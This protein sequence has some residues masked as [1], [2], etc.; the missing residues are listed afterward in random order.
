MAAIPESHRDLLEQ[1]VVVSL[2]TVLPNDQP[3]V[4]PV[5]ADYDGRYI[6]VNTDARRQKVKAM[7]ERPQVTILAVDPNNPYRYLEVRGTVARISEEGADRHIDAL[8][9]QYIGA[10]TYPYRQ[11]DDQR[12][13]C[14]IE[15]KKA[16]P[17]G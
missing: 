15:P 3:Q 10:D 7:R 8:A 12:V 6:R 14:Y 17:Y 2:A 1:P 4:T 5:W 16:I 11:P 9:K 13:I